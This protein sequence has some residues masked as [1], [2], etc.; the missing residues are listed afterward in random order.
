MTAEHEPYQ[1]NGREGKILGGKARQCDRY[2][3]IHFRGKKMA[4]GVKCRE[5][6]RQDKN[7]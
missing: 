6:V 7:Q 5:E 1:G 3:R 4:N 2:H